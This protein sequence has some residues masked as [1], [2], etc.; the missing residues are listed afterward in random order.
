MCLIHRWCR[1]HGITY[2]SSV[3]EWRYD[4]DSV[5]SVVVLFVIMVGACASHIHSLVDFGFRVWK[6][7]K[8]LFVFWVAGMNHFVL[9]MF[10]VQVLYVGECVVGRNDHTIMTVLFYGV[11]D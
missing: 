6:R 1:C 4:I 3:C 10:N 7:L 2:N 8:D 9:C 11:Y 5:W